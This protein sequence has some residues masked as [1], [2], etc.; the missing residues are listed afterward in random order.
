MEFYADVGWFFISAR[1]MLLTHSIPLVG[2]TSSH[3][4]L[5]QGA[6][7]TYLLA[8]VLK[9]T[10]FSPLAAGYFTAVLGV[11]TVGV[12]Y[13]VAKEIINKKVGLI[14]AFIYATSP[15]AIM[16]GR[17]PYHTA[18]IPL[19][20][21]I[22]IYTTFKWVKG[23]KRFFPISLFIIGILYNLEIATFSLT[24]TFLLILI[25]GLVKKASWT[26]SLLNP[27][28]VAY[29]LFALI[30]PMTPMILYDI[31]HGF[32]QTLKFAV[33]VVYRIAVLFGFPTVTSN[34]PGETWHTFAVYNLN[35][36][37][38][39]LFLG[40][41]LIALAI[42]LTTLMAYIWSVYKNTKDKTR[43]GKILL[44]IFFILPTLAFLAQKT[45][46]GAYLLMLYSQMIILIGVAV[47]SFKNKTVV[48]GLIL[49]VIAIGVFNV[50]SL[51]KNNYFSAISYS[52]RLQ[53]AREI[54]E[55]SKGKPFNIITRG[56][57]SQYESFVTP[58]NYL[59]W[60]LGHPAS[61]KSEKLKFYVSEYPGKIKLETK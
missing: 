56:Q 46:S 58:Y 1:D 12:L 53:N 23:D 26:K 2:I 40:N 6:L 55:L 49:L 60:Y 32:P 42:L 52:I 30:I 41:G 38:Q 15:L 45:N 44:L 13:F 34:P 36:L 19:F 5:H 54:I 8:F 22:L 3:T 18:V 35:V 28:T 4:W 11:I 33:W 10:N 47:T 50:Q 14:S 27:K 24:G 31:H 59:V 37:Q 21:L 51:L 39:I 25:Y 16:N 57:G 7:W 20:T 43:T 9:I 29:S 17:V 61:E 48:S